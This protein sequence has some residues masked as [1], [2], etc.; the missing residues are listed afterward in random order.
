MISQPI[1]TTAEVAQPWVFVEVVDGRV[2]ALQLD[3]SSLGRQREPELAAT[4]T[5]ATNRA[6]EE[7]AAQLLLADDEPDVDRERALAFVRNAPASG[8][9]IRP[10]PE[11]DAQAGDATSAVIV[12]GLVEAL[13]IDE[14]LLD[15]GDA[16]D[17]EQAIR[18]AINSALAAYEQGLADRLADADI[19]AVE[20]S[21]SWASLARSI[22]RIERGLL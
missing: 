9:A 6:L 4:I 10:R 22:D 19:E 12:D 18:E 7:Q 8:E 15:R 21:P 17:V 2:A 1:R 11:P 13:W 20:A 14:I 5:L 3:R 16:V